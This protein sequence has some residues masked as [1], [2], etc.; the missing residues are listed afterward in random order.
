MRSLADKPYG[1]SV[2]LLSFMQRVAFD[3]SLPVAIKKGPAEM[4]DRIA[5]VPNSDKVVSVPI[6]LDGGAMTAKIIGVTLSTDQAA[7]KRR[8]TVYS[9]KLKLP[10]AVYLYATHGPTL[11]HK[12]TLKNIRQATR[13][14]AVEMDVDRGHKVYLLA[15]EMAT[16]PAYSEISVKIKAVGKVKD[17]MVNLTDDIV[18]TPKPWAKAQNRTRIAMGGSIS[19][20]GKYPSVVRE[21]KGPAG[22][23]ILQMFTSVQWGDPISLNL[24]VDFKPSK[25]FDWKHQDVFPGGGKDY[26]G[27]MRTK[28]TNPRIVVRDN[29]TRKETEHKGYSL[30]F[31]VPPGP[32]KD[33]SKKFQ[34]SEVQFSGYISLMF[35][36]ECKFVE[37][38]RD[39]QEIPRGTKKD[40]VRF[41]LANYI[42]MRKR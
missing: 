14:S 11:R 21:V 33:P 24:D 8:V 20:A 1:P 16:R 26:S 12:T 22:G 39:G 29:K 10:L 4:I 18:I 30:K 36:C 37:V 2:H 42:I 19:G 32:S 31:A 34:P 17:K 13:G 7:G 6:K 9:D 27:Y 40:K 38:T 5:R 35:D 3:P 41:Y 15:V 28:L 25:G 23:K